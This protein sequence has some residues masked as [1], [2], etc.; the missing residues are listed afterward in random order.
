MECNSSQL[1]HGRSDSSGRTTKADRDHLSAG[2]KATHGCS[3]ARDGQETDRS[4]AETADLQ[5]A[6]CRLSPHQ[7]ARADWG[8]RSAD[9]NAA[10]RSGGGGQMRYA[11]PGTRGVSSC[12]SG[13]RRVD[14]G[15][16]GGTGAA[17]QP[18][19]AADK[20]MDGPICR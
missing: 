18:V 6:D 8:R 15:Q 14:G 20:Q 7:P 2:G 13:P 11:A 9:V 12:Q 4:G 19:N 17:R 1:S 3:A 5:T 16:S 10:K